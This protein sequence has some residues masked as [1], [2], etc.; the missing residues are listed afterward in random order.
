MKL[1]WQIVKKDLLRLRLPLALWAL[2]FLW[3]F[4]LGVRLLRGEATDLYLFER[5]KLYDLVACGLQMA[6]G[7][8]LVAALVHEDPLVGTTSFWPTRPISGL[9]LLGAKLTGCLAIF[10][11]LPALVTLPWWLYCGY[12]A[13]EILCASLD[14]F[15]LRLLPLAAGFAVAALTATM[16]GFLIGTFLIVAF[17]VISFTSFMKPVFPGDMSDARI[18]MLAGLGLTGFLIA[19]AHQ[20]LTRRLIRSIIVLGCFLGVLL[21]AAVSRPLN[22]SHFIEHA[23]WPMPSLPVSDQV[24]FE[25]A[26]FSQ[27]D[28]SSGT[29]ADFLGGKD[30]GPGVRLL[31]TFA[32]KSVPAGL[33]MTLKGADFTWNWR[34]GTQLSS[35]GWLIWPDLSFNLPA[36]PFPP[37]PAG[38]EWWEWERAHG[39]LNGARAAKTY[40]EFRKSLEGPRPSVGFAVV[41]PRLQAVRMRSDPPGCTVALT[42]DLVRW[43]PIPDFAFAPGRGWEGDAQGIRVGHMEWNLKNNWMEVGVVEHHPEIETVFGLKPNPP[44]FW[45]DPINRSRRESARWRDGGSSRMRIATVVVSW[46]RESLA[47]PS[48]WMADRWVEETPDWFAGATVAGGFG[49]VVSRF[50]TKV[51]LGEFV[52]KP[53]AAETAPP[54]KD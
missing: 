24:A 19:A 23:E 37:E 38:R 44:L 27:A 33:S 2:T 14:S 42:G 28:F 5:L 7:Y 21:L 4:A 52:L 29:E 40:D 51:A 49:T 36:Q 6:I 25:F 47:A 43:D 35:P 32:V 16:S 26:E 50:E 15:S 9:R 20:F 12:G 22:L 46:T 31:S 30:D 8:V 45:F 48:H 10:G 13:R 39:R 3:E 11:V 53:P 17:A 34:D 18:W 1:T 41:V 54:K